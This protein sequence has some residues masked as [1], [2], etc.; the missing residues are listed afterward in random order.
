MQNTMNALYSIAS[1]RCRFSSWCNALWDPHPGHLRP[2]KQKNGHFGKKYSDGSNEEY[3][4]M[5]KRIT[6]KANMM[7][8][9]LGISYD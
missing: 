9:L 6:T 3:T 2:V 5:P 7:T 1:F 8:V 4:T